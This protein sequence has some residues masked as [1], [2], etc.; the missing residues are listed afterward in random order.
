METTNLKIE[1]FERA[2]FFTIRDNIESLEIAKYKESTMKGN[3]YLQID[4]INFT[5]LKKES[6]PM[7]VFNRLRNYSTPK[8]IESSIGKLLVWD[9]YAM[10]IK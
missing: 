9:H 5:S 3:I 2:V 8:L 6:Y 1:D 4:K 10:R 7:Q